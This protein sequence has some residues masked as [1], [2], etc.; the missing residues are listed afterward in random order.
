MANISKALKSA[1]INEIIDSN[2]ATK[3]EPIKVKE[4]TADYYTQDELLQLME[5]IKFTP[6]E[7]PVIIAG[8]Y[9]LR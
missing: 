2:P 4:Y 6:I 9:G 7:L 3:L 1:V 5:I 8:V